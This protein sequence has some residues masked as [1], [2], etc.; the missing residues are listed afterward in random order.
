M[1]TVTERYRDGLRNRDREME[2]KTGRQ[3][4]EQG[5]TEKQRQRDGDS[6]RETET[7]RQTEVRLCYFLTNQL[8]LYADLFI[9][10]DG[11]SYIYNQKAKDCHSKV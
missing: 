11:K 2:T 8:S 6:D 10:A 3:R 9:P 4:Q 5:Q 1:E 7:E